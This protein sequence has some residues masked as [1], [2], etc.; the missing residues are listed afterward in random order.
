[1]TDS[2]PTPL[3]AADRDGP[4]DTLAGVLRDTGQNAFSI[5]DDPELFRALCERWSRHV[6]TGAPPP[7]A[8]ADAP[9]DDDR[10]WPKL[11]LFYRSRRQAEREYV[12]ARIDE[13]KD[14]IWDIVHG[15]RTISD[16]GS[17]TEAKVDESIAMLETAA[18]SD[19]LDT[20]RAALGPAVRNIRDAMAAQRAEFSA[21]MAR[22]TTRLDDMRSDLATA[23]EQMQL[24]A[25][26]QVYNRGAFDE[27][28]TRYIDL[29]MLSHQP[30]NLMMID[31]DHFKS[32]NDRY[33]HP[34]GDQVLK[35]GAETLVRT[36]LRKNDFVARYG[37]EEFA[38]ILGDT[39]AGV[40]PRL[41][42]NAL[43]AIRALIVDADGIEIRV[44][45]SIGYATLRPGES[46]AAFV[47]R[48]DAALY[49]AK[50]EGRDRAVGE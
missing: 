36:F 11:K 38:V 15:L 43:K 9:P 1:M 29:A 35:R 39:P 31:F 21:E 41:A 37:G 48:A 50:D 22:M 10:Q 44:T 19:S 20:V 6:L 23:R 12:T 3:V 4:L 18:M 47:A 46:A 32:I 14:I 16:A 33:G 34:V 28:L 26:T 30:L 24:D 17:E 27:A 2:Q 8:D 42:K 7:G 45:A 49:A 40:V 13:F 5:G 25:L